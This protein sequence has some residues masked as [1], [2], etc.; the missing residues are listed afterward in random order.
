MM[1]MSVIVIVVLMTVFAYGSVTV[2]IGVNAGNWH[3]WHNWHRMQSIKASSQVTIMVDASVPLTLKAFFDSLLEN[4]MEKSLVN[5]QILDEY[6][7]NGLVCK[8]RRF[9][10][11]STL[12]IQ[13]LT[14]FVIWIHQ[15]NN[16]SI[17]D[18]KYHD[19]VISCTMETTS[20][21]S[22]PNDLSMLIF[23][24]AVQY[25]CHPYL[26]R[27]VCK[28]A[29]NCNLLERVPLSRYTLNFAPMDQWH[30][31]NILTGQTRL[32]QW[33]SLDQRVD[34]IGVCGGEGGDYKSYFDLYIMRSWIPPHLLTDH[35]VRC[36]LLNRVNNGGDMERLRKLV[37]DYQLALPLIVNRILALMDTLA[38]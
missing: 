22:L 15:K 16:Y 28:A 20:F 6:Q 37:L 21:P 29:H 38:I 17:G 27:A 9:D 31:R 26:I 7:W 25:G 8:Q 24:Q 14:A 19:R 35:Y 2:R 18:Q 30:Q 32:W 4:E 13:T 10:G 36:L 23:K 1:M 34:V 3:N 12:S 33:L 5:A 11:E